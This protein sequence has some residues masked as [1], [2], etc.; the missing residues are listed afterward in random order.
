MIRAILV[1]DEINAI[2]SLEWEVHNFSDKVS[3][4][5]KYTSPEEAIEAI[6][7]LEPDCVFLDIEMPNMDGFQLLSKLAYRKFDLII[8][9]AYDNY[10]IK[11]FKE[12]AIDYLLKPVDTDDLIE[13]IT[14]IEAN[15][16][17]KT[18]GQQLQKMFGEIQQPKTN[19]FSKI[20]LSVSGKLI[21]VNPEDIM[22]CKAEGN[23]TTVYLK[24]NKKHL[25]SKKIKD[26]I[27]SF[28][29]EDF[30][31]IHKSYHVNL[32]AIKEIVK[33]EGLYIILENGQNIPVSRTKKEELIS[34]LSN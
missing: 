20:Q 17:S 32:N 5:G 1:D 10:A 6:N 30:F 3:I 15:R 21:F 13:A 31:R 11:A 14:R 19:H 16:E 34:R 25:L 26:V 8:T 24:D 7:T 33:N 18:I 12:N 29:K 22:Y 4:V 2:K 27:A 9:T 23:Y 28:P